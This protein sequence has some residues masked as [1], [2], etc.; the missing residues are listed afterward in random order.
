MF[1]N[2]YNKASAAFLVGL[3]VGLLG[4]I[5][6]GG[7]AVMSMDGL[8]SHMDFCSD[9]SSKHFIFDQYVRE[10]VCWPD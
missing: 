10:K 1:W 9:E 5:L 4:G 7:F 8:N 3:L 2:A 6:L